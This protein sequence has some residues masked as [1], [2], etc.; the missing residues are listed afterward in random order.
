MKYAKIFSILVFTAIGLY[1][2]VGLYFLP[3][4]GFEGDQTRIGL[5]PEILFGWTM[6]QPAVNP[7]L[8][9]QATWQDADVLVIGDSFSVGRIWQ[10]ELVRHGLR[11]H[12][13][14]WANIRGICEDFTPWLNSK[15]FKGKYIVLE[16]VE[17]NVASGFAQ[18]VRCNKMD[19]HHS[20]EA[21]MPKGPPPTVID[22]KK[23]DYSGKISIGLQTRLNQSRYERLSAQPDFKSWDTGRGSIVARIANGCD[24]FSHARCADA[25]LLASDNVEDLSHSVVNDMQTLDTRMAGFK[26][27]WVVVPNKTTAYLHPD[28]HF[29]DEAGS[30]V[31]SLN[32]LRIVRQ[33]IE[34]K[35]VD[36]YPANNQHFSTTTYLA[37]GRAIYQEMQ[38]EPQNK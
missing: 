31:H 22:R 16:A 5:L 4:A 1:G 9:R 33:A 13:E 10:T 20:V 37:M 25:L 30:R 35:T 18:Y 36:V 23:P 8:I 28:K 24:L 11:V 6:P 38:Q 2:T 17:R 21:E 34:A 27:L 29:W 3:L 15:G 7:A 14:H 19:F 32:L 26:T 12:T